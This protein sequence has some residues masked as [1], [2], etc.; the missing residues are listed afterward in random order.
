MKWIGTYFVLVIL[1]RNGEVDETVYWTLICYCI[2]G[3]VEG[4]VFCGIIGETV[5]MSDDEYHVVIFIVVSEVV[6]VVLVIG[7]SGTNSMVSII[8]NMVRI[9][10][11]GCDVVLVVIFYYNKF[12]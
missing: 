12:I 1:F 4:I 5:I 9:R 6:G 10:E 8:C 3:G 11:L 2:D 7:G